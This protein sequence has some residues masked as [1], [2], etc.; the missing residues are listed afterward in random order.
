MGEQT[1]VWQRREF[2][3]GMKPIFEG[4]KSQKSLCFFVKF[5]SITTCNQKLCGKNVAEMWHF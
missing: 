1:Q 2:L 5:F 3:Q 4:K